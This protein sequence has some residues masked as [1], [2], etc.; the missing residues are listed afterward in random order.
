METIYFLFSEEN[1]QHCYEHKYIF[2]KFIGQII[3]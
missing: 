3:S 1:I 2:K